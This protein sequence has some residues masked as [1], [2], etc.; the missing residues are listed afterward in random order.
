MKWFRKVTHYECE[1]IPRARVAWVTTLS[2]ND[3]G[4]ILRRGLM[5]R[6]AFKRWMKFINPWSFG[7]D[8][9]FCTFSFRLVYSYQSKKFV[10]DKTW[11]PLQVEDWL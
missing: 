6:T 11:E 3:D 1:V 2:S 10:F 4:V 9:G 5:V 8:E 7:H